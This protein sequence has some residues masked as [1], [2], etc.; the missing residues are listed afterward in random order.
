M[1]MPSNLLTA[2]ELADKLSLSVE[3]IWRYTRQRKIPFIDLGHRQYRYD[4]EEVLASLASS[5]KVNETELV[6]GE[7]KRKFT[8]QDYLQFLEEPGF[9]YEILDGT[10]VKEPSPDYRHQRVSRRL[11][12]I[13]ED[14]FAEKDPMGE[15]FYAPLDVTLSEYTVVQPDIFYISSRQQSLYKYPRI[16]GAPE[17]VIEIVSL[18]SHSRDRVKKLEVYREAKVQHYWLV[19]PQARTIEAYRYSDGTYV[20]AAGAEGESE[21]THPDFPDLVIALKDLFVMRD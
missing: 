11:H 4:P 7:E 1:T 16:D 12:R 2:Q 9:H 15:V 8:Y 21:F 18:T 3:T 17:L 14:Y 13:L 6:S 20:W 5:S 19:D 10:V